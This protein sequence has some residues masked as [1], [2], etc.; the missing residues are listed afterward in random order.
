MATQGT[1]NYQRVSPQAKKKLSGILK[2]NRTT[3]HPVTECIRALV[4]KHG[5]PKDRAA[6]ICAVAKDTAL[7]STHWRGK[8]K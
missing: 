8:G 4:T 1:Y 7:K 5:M 6:R 3:A 2:W